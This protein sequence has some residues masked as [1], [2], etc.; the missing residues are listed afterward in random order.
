MV[1]KRFLNS[2]L[3]NNPFT[4]EKIMK[5]WVLKDQDGKPTMD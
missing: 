4:G 5:K 1:N 2:Y 3:K